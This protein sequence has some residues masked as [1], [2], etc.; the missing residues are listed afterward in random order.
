M[1]RRNP[2]AGKR[3]GPD[4]FRSLQAAYAQYEKDR[5]LHG[6]GEAGLA[7]RAEFAQIHGWSEGL[8]FGEKKP[9]KY[10][11]RVRRAQP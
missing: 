4:Q 3:Y 7:P 6:G 10:M 9:S 1:T 2:L 11:P 5:L 8:R